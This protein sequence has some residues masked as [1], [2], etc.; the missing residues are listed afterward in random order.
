MSEFDQVPFGGVEFADN[1]EPRCACVL[2]LDT[3]G[4]MS[5]A[6][7]SELNAGLQIFAEELRSDAMAAKR[8]EVAIV[9]FGPVQ[10]AQ[11]FVTADAFQ[12]PHLIASGDTPM[13][14]AIQNAVALVAERKATYKA[15][16]IGYYRPWLFLIT[17]GAPT[18]DV[19]A[20]TAAIR[21]G[22]A[23]VADALCGRGRG[24]GH[25]SS[26]A[27]RRA[28][29]AQAAWSF[30]PRAVCLVVQF[31]GRRSAF[32]ARRGGPTYKSDSARRLGRRRLNRV[33]GG[34]RQPERR[35]LRTSGRGFPVKTGSRARCCPVTT[36]WLPLPMGQDRRQR[37][38]SAPRLLSRSSPRRSV[39]RLK[40]ADRI[41]ISF[42][43][44]PRRKPAKR[45]FP[46][47]SSKGRSHGASRQLSLS[48]WRRR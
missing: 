40:R 18:D 46:K 31:A 47:L 8:V 35:G 6:K 34:S 33:C 2:L 9:T 29:S 44:R 48:W 38:A 4:S 7:I 37:A 39:V 27:D 14:A 1:P 24:G 30:L 22:E 17:D 28:S 32:S 15:N 20:A 5:G 11:H 19:S 21:E 16:G 25:E 13:G 45:F 41:F 42:Y 43:G 3:S 26:R 36:W 10:T 23:S 12:A